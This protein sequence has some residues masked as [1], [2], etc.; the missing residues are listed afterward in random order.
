MIRKANITLLVLIMVGLMV[1]PSM[2]AQTTGWSGS[3]TINQMRVDDTQFA[4]DGLAGDAILYRES[5]TG[6][7]ELDDSFAGAI[8]GG[9]TV[10]GQ[11]LFWDQTGGAVWDITT[12]GAGVNELFWDDVNK[13]LGI[14]PDAD[15]DTD[16]AYLVVED[17]TLTTTTDF[18]GMG[19]VIT[20][21]AGVTDANDD[22]GAMLY[23]VDLNQAGGIV[24]DL[25][26]LTG[27]ADFT[28]GTATNLIGIKT[29]T[30]MGAGG[31][32]TDNFG[33]RNI[34]TTAAAS[35]IGD[36]V[37]GNYCTVNSSGG[38]GGEL[39]GSFTD[40]IHTAGAVVSNGIGT[41]TVLDV[42]GGSA[43]NYIGIKN[44][45]TYDAATATDD[46]I[47]ISNFMDVNTITH[48]D[49]A[50]VFNN[51]LTLGGNCGDD[52]L[53]ITN[54]LNID[55]DIGG[56]MWG[57]D[58]DIDIA[59]TFTV[60]NDLIANAI[61]VN[62][63]GDI[64]NDLTGLD[65]EIDQA[66]NTVAGDLSGIRVDIAAADVTGAEYGIYNNSTEVNPWEAMTIT[67]GD[68]DNAVL[69][70]GKNCR[71]TVTAAD[72]ASNI[73]GLTTGVDGRKITLLNFTAAETITLEDQEIA[74]GGGFSPIITC[75]GLDVALAGYS[76]ATLIYSS[77]DSAW[78]L[79]ST[80]L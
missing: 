43:V 69:P 28:A 51:A 47:G 49:D 7:I 26:G 72:N 65:I 61:D 57:I 52:L 18:Y 22:I 31:T 76:N 2:S 29:G 53:G 16:I 19:S 45:N 63:V 5:T 78:I 55:A 6:R 71:I 68:N 9:G 50:I 67:N 11:M 42:N 13:S 8:L 59:D 4:A 35:T 27:G 3:A 34:N 30:A 10:D 24:G 64:G 58:T 20:K 37:Y 39:I 25:V 75:S 62:V 60:T 15:D 12:A 23:F 77:A 40:T 1:M 38:I 21:T 17:D 48:T 46:I 33:I 44:V 80:T 32:S 66:T 56:D 41:E 54:S 14:G 70:V 36:T 79:V 73:G 74:E